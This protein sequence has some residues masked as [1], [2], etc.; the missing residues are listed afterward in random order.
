MQ[1]R[2]VS[3]EKRL[4]RYARKNRDLFYTAHAVSNMS[5]QHKHCLPTDCARYLTCKCRGLVTPS[6]SHDSSFGWVLF[7]P[8]LLAD[9][10]ARQH[11]CDNTNC[12]TTT[13]LPHRG[14]RPCQVNMPK[15][16]VC[17]P[18]SSGWNTKAYKRSAK[19]SF[20]S[21]KTAKKDKL[22]SK[23]CDAAADAISAKLEAYQKTGPD[24]AH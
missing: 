20:R 13:G 4:P 17:R 7:V 5:K 1:Y 19:V 24:D 8:S 6:G 22:I 23:R 14:C 10:P 12:S 16:N 15:K 3:T 9:A 11:V 18:N 2:A 21:P